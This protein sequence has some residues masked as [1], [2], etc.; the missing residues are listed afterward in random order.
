MHYAK[1]FL[2]NQKDLPI[3]SKQFTHVVKLL[4]DQEGIV[5]TIVVVLRD[6]KSGP[7]GN[8]SS[9]QAGQTLELT[10]SV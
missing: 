3:C 8:H 5:Q 2:D 1:E 10:V 6:N 9:Q 7:R 4:P